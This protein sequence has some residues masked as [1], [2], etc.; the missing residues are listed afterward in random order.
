MKYSSYRNSQAWL[1]RHPDW[2]ACSNNRCQLFPWVRVGIVNGKYHKYNVHHLH[3]NAY[4]RQNKERWQ[5]DVIVLCPFAH[6][7]VFHWLLSGG[8]TTV[9]KQK[10][11]PNLAQRSL[12]WWCRFV[13]IMVN[14]P[15]PLHLIALF[16]GLVVLQNVRT[17]L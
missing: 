5:R 7:F 8:K 1:S 12:N 3:R 17:S 16:V 13:G 4:R 11:F 14:I 9:G 6:K 10:D 2:L 15:A